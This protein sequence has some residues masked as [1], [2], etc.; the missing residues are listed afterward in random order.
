MRCCKHTLKM[1]PVLICDALNTVKRE[2]YWKY[3]GLPCMDGATTSEGLQGN[4][5]YFTMQYCFR[6]KSIVD[7]KQKKNRNHKLNH[8]HPCSESDQWESKPWADGVNRS[9]FQIFVLAETELV[10]RKKQWPPILIIA[11][12][13]RSPSHLARNMHVMES[14][15]PICLH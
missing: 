2:E 4:R 7:R 6:G 14:L 3:S 1:L 9:T 12:Q 11:E 13:H 15:I 5:H 8:C 10:L